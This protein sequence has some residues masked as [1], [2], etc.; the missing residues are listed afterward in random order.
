MSSSVPA[1]LLRRLGQSLILLFLV[2]VIGFMVIHL[3]PGGPLA[4][5]AL[6]PG[7]TQADAGA[8]RAPDGPRSPAA[9]A[10]LGVAAA[11]C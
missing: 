5:F 8:H 7:M 11:T 1:F 2:S 6:T 4:Q 9:G 3:A 10:I